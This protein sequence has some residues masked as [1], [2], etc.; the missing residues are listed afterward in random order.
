L[1]RNCQDLSAQV[2]GL[3]GQTPLI[4]R[5]ESDNFHVEVRSLSLN[6]KIMLLTSPTPLSGS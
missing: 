6:L 1:P 5:V 2:R 3:R 4:E